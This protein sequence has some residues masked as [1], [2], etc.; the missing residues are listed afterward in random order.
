MTLPVKIIIPWRPSPD[1]KAGFEWLVKYYTHR[2]GAEAVHIE[3]D[4]TIGPFNKSK[5][6]NT[7]IEQFPNHICVIADADVFI[8]DWSLRHAIRLAEQYDFLYIPHNSVCR[9]T[10]IESTKVLKTSPKARPSGRMFRN[11]R[12]KPAPGGMWI[13][14]SDLFLKYQMNESF[15][16]WGF[17]DNEFLSRIPHIR[18]AGP[19]FHF[20]H[21]KA[22]K[23]HWRSNG[24]VMTKIRRGRGIYRGL[25]IQQHPKVQSAFINLLAKYPPIRIL[26]IGT[27]GGGFTLMLRDLAPDIPIRTHDIKP[28]PKRNVL[29]KFN[30]DWKVTD[31]L[32]KDNLPDTTEFIT[33]PG[34]TLILC[35]GGN[36]RKEIKIIANIAKPGDIV[37]A[38]DYAPNLQV[39]KNN[40][41][42][43]QWDWCEI[44]DADIPTNKLR[45]IRMPQ[46][47]YVVW[48]C[49]EAL[50]SENLN[51]T[52][53]N[54][55]SS[56]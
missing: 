8:C 35:D 1:R 54:N 21:T 11:R 18:L 29:T 19:L 47:D 43:K 2:F 16:G 31:P 14:R 40:I 24:I 51:E 26:E 10:S 28:C 55:D 20:W 33:S 38:H 52:P 32:T 50:P 56:I 13:V 12:T 3:T 36:K 27:A 39:F 45:K 30:I 5:I 25:P 37:M 41:L 34:R 48:F 4:K 22:S 6:L 15:K 49:G 44:T 17:E 23:E 53:Q 42:R 46:L 9:M 7:A